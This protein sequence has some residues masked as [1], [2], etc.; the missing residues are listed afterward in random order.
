MTLTS[1]ARH[2]C[3]QRRGV[4]RTDQGDRANRPGMQYRGG[5][6]DKSA[7]GMTNQGGRCVAQGANQ[8][9]GIP[10]EGPAV[11]A[12]RWFITAAV[13]AKINRHDPSPGQSAQLMSPRPP[14]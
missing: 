12:A 3:P 11:V 4:G 6:A 2:R 1:A 9:G 10:G 5:P 14:E 7:V 8:A 13:P